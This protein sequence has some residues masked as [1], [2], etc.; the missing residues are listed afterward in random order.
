MF[1]HKCSTIIPIIL[2]PLLHVLNIFFFF[3]SSCF[4]TG[5]R[6]STIGPIYYEYG[7]MVVTFDSSTSAVQAYELVRNSAYEE[8]KL[9]G[10]KKS[11]KATEI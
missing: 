9:L 2:F 5:C 3:F 8:K 4:S 10:K 7:S 1:S 6:F 11:K